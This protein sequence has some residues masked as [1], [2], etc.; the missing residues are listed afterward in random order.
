AACLA[1]VADLVAAAVDRL[2]VVTDADEDGEW[3]GTARGDLSGYGCSAVFGGDDADGT[4]LPPPL[5]IGAYLLDAAGVP[6][7]RRRY[8]A[9]A[10]T[11]SPA[12]C[13]AIGR[14]LVGAEHRIGLLV[15]ADGS[16]K[17]TTSSPGYLDRRAVD[18]DADVV[19]AL[20]D[21]DLDAL[22]ALDPALAAE[23]WVAGRP[24][25]QVLSGAGRQALADGAS[26]S[27]RATYD[28]APYGVGYAVVE[29]L[30]SYP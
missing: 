14:A 29:W 25:W 6:V 28:A 2:V 11:T 30:L 9:H 16:A 22:D 5:T 26:I 20:L 24:G 13:A 10:S 7:Q 1:A 21:V 12:D 27:T 23:L 4:G 8:L 18:Y 15:L 19:R 3:S 17:R